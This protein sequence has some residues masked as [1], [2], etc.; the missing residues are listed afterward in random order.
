MN[1]PNTN[2]AARTLSPA[3]IAVLAL[4]CALVIG[5]SQQPTEPAQ[6]DHGATVQ[7]LLPPA[8]PTTPPTA[9]AVPT[10]AEAAASTSVPPTDTP[11][12]PPTYTPR[13]APTRAGDGE[14][15]RA[16]PFQAQTL[17]G[18]VLTLSDTLGSPTLLAFWAPW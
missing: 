9:T 12:P 18:S 16:T 5:C 8:E 1:T 15:E 6:P 14:R 7:A 3:L 2:A 13:P 10:P 4:L 17:D 11:L